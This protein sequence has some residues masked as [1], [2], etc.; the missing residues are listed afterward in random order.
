MKSFVHS[1][2]RILNIRHLQPVRLEEEPPILELPAPHR[3][4]FLP[5]NPCPHPK[6]RDYIPLR[7]FGQI[8]ERHLRVTSKGNFAIP[9]YHRPGL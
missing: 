4:D 2:Q 9:D 3:S 5:I 8:D 6:P 1:G 7:D